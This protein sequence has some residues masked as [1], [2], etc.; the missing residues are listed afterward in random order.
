M[1]ATIA[2]GGPS[3]ATAW[4][5]PVA[6][7]RR[8]WALLASALVW[9]L[10]VLNFSALKLVGSDALVQY[11]FAQRLYG[12]APTASGYYFG[13]GLTEAPFY[14]LGKLLDR[15]GVHSLDGNPIRQASVALGLGLLTLVAWPLL[16]A[17]L[18]GLRLR[19][20]GPVLLASAIGMPVLYYATIVPEKNHDVDAVLFTVVVYLTYRYFSQPRPDRWVPFALGIALGLSYTVR[21]FS[22]AETVGLLL[23]LLWCRRWLHAAQ[24]AVTSVAV[25]L[26]LLA[27]PWALH[28]PIFV[29]VSSADSV[30]IFAPLNPLRMLFT[31]HRGLFVWSPVSAVAVIG[32]VLLFVRRPEHRRFLAAATAMGVAIIS[33]YSLIA[34]WDGT[35]AFSQ[36]FFTPLFPLVVIGLAGLVNAAPRLGLAAATLAAAWTLFLAL[37]LTLIGGPQYLS[38]TPGGA[39]DLALVPE[40]THTSPGAYLWGMYHRSNL[41][42]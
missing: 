32:F 7:L 35:W 39:S 33:S 23:V 17:V 16:A 41:L 11:G 9:I 27:I 1:N 3:A 30:L 31:D 5:R 25:F 20:A 36:R 10:F 28:V 2:G 34:F 8:E 42:P 12:D 19:Y 4:S 22:G 14:G 29:G 24:I 6:Y 26:L 21:Y 18:K 15:V 38:D 13:L 37:N 40:R